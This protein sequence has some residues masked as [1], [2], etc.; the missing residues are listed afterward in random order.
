MC[1]LQWFGDLVTCDYWGELWLNEGFATYFEHYAATAAQ[2]TYRYY[3][4]FF[5]SDASYGLLMDAKNISTHPLATLQGDSNLSINPLLCVLDPR[6]PIG[7]Q[8]IL[9]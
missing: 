5:A 2:P 1:H 4:T 8:L 9:T 7:L 3:D 6:G